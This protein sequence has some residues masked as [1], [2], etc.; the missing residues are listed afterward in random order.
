[1]INLWGGVGGCILSLS[2]SAG[3]HGVQVHKLYRLY[4]GG[5][6]VRSQLFIISGAGGRGVLYDYVCVCA[7]WA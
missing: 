3:M 1:M 6:V 2:C 5:G 7:V 4:R